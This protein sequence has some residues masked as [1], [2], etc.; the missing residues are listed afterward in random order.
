MATGATRVLI[1]EDDSIL[2]DLLCRMLSPA[3]FSCIP[4]GSAEEAL[5]SLDAEPADVLITDIKLPGMSGLDLTEKIMTSGEM[6]AL[7]MTGF[8]DEY[9]YAHAI[10]KGA[11]DF[12][13]KPVRAEE[14]V[15]RINRAVREREQSKERTRALE[16][17]RK[18]AITDEL[19]QLFNSRHFYSQ[20]KI[21]IDRAN[22][23]KRDL[24]LLLL[25]I[26]H[27]KAYNDEHG[28]LEGNVVL[29]RL[30][31]VVTACLR[32]MDSAYRYG[33]EEFTMILPETDVK[34]GNIVAERLRTMMETQEFRPGAGDRIGITISVGITQY[35]PGEELT[36]FVQRADQAMYKA[37]DAGRNRTDTLLA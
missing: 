9:T 26:D 21:E 17:I 13:M 29:S 24:S 31:S 22:R 2:R 32:T 28:H 27:F 16:Q 18:L 6:V 10:E 20:L 37:K 12:I 25:D 15:L 5:E 1:V 30:G 19:T 11:S 35:V 23:Y 34:D 33:G 36:T 4:V 3:G 7:V 8:I 14:I